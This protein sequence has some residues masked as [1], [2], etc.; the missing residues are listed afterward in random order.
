MTRDYRMLA[1]VTDAFGGRGG[2]AQYNRDLF[3]ALARSKDVNIITVLPRLTPDRFATPC[4]VIQKPPR[5]DRFRYA[6][7]AIQEA[8]TAR[9]HL[10]FC[11]HL[12]MAPLAALLAWLTRAKLIVQMHG[13]EAWTRP[14]RVYR[15]AVE[16]ADVVLCVSRFTKAAVRSWAAMAPERMLVLPNTI[17]DHFKPGDAS[18]LRTALGLRD[19]RVLLTVARMDSRERYKGHERVI[20]AIPML[21]AAGHD[22]VY[23]IVGEG[24]DRERLAA[25]ACEVGVAARVRFVGAVEGPKLID[26]YQ[27]ADLYV[28][29]STG[30]G[31]GIAFLE[32]MASGTPALGLAVGGAQDALADGDLGICVDEP[33]FAAALLR[34]LEGPKRHPEELLCAVRARFERQNFTTA[35]RAAIARALAVS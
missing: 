31:F 3:G 15:M 1:L 35:A 10:V 25:R 21:V 18:G 27:A 2:I 7:A 26:F 12:Y 8:L 9:P 16:A 24:D 17:G 29:P 13:I 23:L 30:E 6:V 32:A 11:G 22:I 33:G 34:A 28:M 20:D 19:K 4:G 14:S 5:H